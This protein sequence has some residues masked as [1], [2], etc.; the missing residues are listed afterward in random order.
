[1]SDSPKYLSD[2]KVQADYFKSLTDPKRRGG[3]LL[4]SKYG[5]SI[6]MDDW[7]ESFSVT[8]EY[9]HFLHT[10]TVPLNEVIN[11]GET[12]DSQAFKDG[13][14]DYMLD[15]GFDCTP[16]GLLLD[17]DDDK[18][19]Y[20]SRKGNSE[21]EYHIVGDQVFVRIV[22]SFEL[23]GSSYNSLFKDLDLTKFNERDYAG[24]DF[25]P[26]EQNYSDQDVEVHYRNEDSCYA[27]PKIDRDL[28]FS[29][30]SFQFLKQIFPVKYDPFYERDGLIHVESKGYSSNRPVF[31]L[32]KNLKHINRTINELKICREFHDREWL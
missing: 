7:T 21:S 15:H 2:P 6:W 12:V 14:H 31:D 3:P 23:R 20:L 16:K 26:S 10:M 25:K 8:R 13:M 5:S 30:I 11:K 24:E 18:P 19:L 29:W 9:F 17:C 1:M 4:E 22:V 32:P 27:N 28:F